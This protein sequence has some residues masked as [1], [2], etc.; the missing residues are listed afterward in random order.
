VGVARLP[1]LAVALLADGGQARAQPRTPAAA[2]MSPDAALVAAQESGTI[3]VWQRASGQRLAAFPSKGMFRGALARRLL[4]GVVDDER[5]QTWRAPRFAAGRALVH[6]PRVLGLG[7][8]YLSADGRTLASIYPADGGVGDPDSVGAWDVARGTRRAAFRLARGRVQGVALSDDGETL[9]VFGDGAARGASA[10]LE[11]HVLGRR[12]DKLM[13]LEVLRWSGPD[14]STYAAALSRAGTRLALGAGTRLLLFALERGKERL[15][16]A[17]PLAAVKQLFPPA[18]RGPAVELPGAHQIA[19]APDG[20]RLATLHGFGVVG[21]ALWE[22]SPAA[23]PT[24]APLRP[25]SWVKPPEPRPG[26]LRQIAFDPRGGLWL[27][28]AGY[29]PSVW[30]YAARADRFVLERT[31]NP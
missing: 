6:K 5:L 14:R 1:L 15:L 19:F 9:A 23:G 22:V 17:V 26:T 27:I 16:G 3:R 4:A 11:V 30:V 13:S 20:K 31:L 28:A 18:L 29:S 10:Q 8:L 25:T 7:R 12:G 2:V 24:R 21:V